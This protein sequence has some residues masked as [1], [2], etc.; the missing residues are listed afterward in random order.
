[1]FFSFKAGVFFCTLLFIFLFFFFIIEVV[2][3]SSVG[4]FFLV[5]VASFSFVFGGVPAPLSSVARRIFFLSAAFSPAV[6]RTIPLVL[7]ILRIPP[8]SITLIIPTPRRFLP[9]V[10]PIPF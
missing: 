4:G 10:L 1:M 5:S 3:D 2:V 7:P 9:E 6:V 8:P